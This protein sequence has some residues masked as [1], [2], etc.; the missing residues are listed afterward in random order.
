MTVTLNLPPAIERAILAEAQAKGVSLDELVQDK[1]IA[2][3]P[4]LPDP[5]ALPFDEWMRNFEA[6]L[7]SFAGNTVVLPD[8]AMERESIYGD[9]G[10]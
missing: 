2:A 5:N 3:Q 7:A 8:D 10:R 4:C 9:H 1:L 6:L